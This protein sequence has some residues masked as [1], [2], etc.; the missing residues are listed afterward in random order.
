MENVDFSDMTEDYDWVCSM[1]GVKPIL[2]DGSRTRR[3]RLYWT[4]LK[5]PSDI[6]KDMPW[7]NPDEC[8]D[9]GRSFLKQGK[10][11]TD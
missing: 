4:N 5:L 1:L 3:K 10:A 6:E 7:Y 9:E 2:L 8:L 11:F